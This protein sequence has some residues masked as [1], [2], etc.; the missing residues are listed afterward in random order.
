MKYMSFHC[1][2]LHKV[3]V[4]KNHENTSEFVVPESQYSRIKSKKF[5]FVL[6]VFIPYFIEQIDLSMVIILNN[7]S[8]KCH[9]ILVNDDVSYSIEKSVSQRRVWIL[10]SATLPPGIQFI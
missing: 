10:T 3:E 9:I 7:F 2:L 1:S 8:S 5:C 6:I 4:H